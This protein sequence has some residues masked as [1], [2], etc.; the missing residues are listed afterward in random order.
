MERCPTIRA[1]VPL[2][3]HR[4]PAYSR[5]PHSGILRPTEAITRIPYH[6][7]PRPIQPRTLRGGGGGEDRTGRRPVAADR[8]APAPERGRPG[9]PSRSNRDMVNAILWVHRTG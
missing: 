1:M 3:N 4:P 2:P 6:R 5:P 9:R 8:A 7:R